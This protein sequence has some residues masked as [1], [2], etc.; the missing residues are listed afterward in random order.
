MNTQK[1]EFIGINIIVETA[2]LVKA[3]HKNKHLIKK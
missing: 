1:L 3:M 2:F